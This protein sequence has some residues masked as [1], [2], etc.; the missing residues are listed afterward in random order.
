MAKSLLAVTDYIPSN[1]KFLNSNFIRNFFSVKNFVFLVGKVALLLAVFFAK[2]T[3]SIFRNLEKEKLP[4]VSVS[5]ENSKAI[6]KSKQALE[7][8]TN[9]SKSNIF[10]SSTSNQK[11]TTAPTAPITQLKLRLVAINE[12]SSGRKLAIIEDTQKQNQEVFELNDQIFNQAKLIDILKDS[13]RME[14]NGKIE[15]LALEENIG[16]KSPASSSVQDEDKEEID[17]NQTEFSVEE[18]EVSSALAN[19]TQL[20]S[21]ARAV[22]Y[23]RNGQ[24][25]GMRLFAIRSGS[26]YEKLGLKNGDVL[27]SVNDNSLSDPAQALKIFEQ[28]KSERSIGVKLERNSQ[29]MDMHYTVR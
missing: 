7:S 10:G 28:L 5:E 21:Q 9:I 29:N 22:P 16:K 12:I 19:L 25:I 8:Y 13:I 4:E 3:G 6:T 18:E 17:D 11:Q 23:F 1:I 2:S 15:I 27:L 20:L 26:L 24:S 14:R